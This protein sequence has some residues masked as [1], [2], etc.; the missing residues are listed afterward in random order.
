MLPN[1][2]SCDTFVA[3]SDV[4][5]A[6]GDKGN[7]VVFGKNSDRPSG[8]VQEIVYAPGKTIEADEKV[9]VGKLIELIWLKKN[10]QL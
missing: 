3:M 6:A 1:P 2:M 4:V 9:Q 8:E 5:S 10:V 7:G